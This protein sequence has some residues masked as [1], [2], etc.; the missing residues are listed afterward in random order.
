MPLLAR[1]SRNKGR[2]ITAVLKTLLLH[3][4]HSERAKKAVTSWPFVRPMVRR[5]VAGEQLEEAVAVTRRLN[6]QGFRVALNYLGE[7]VRHPEEAERA[8]DEYLRLVRAIHDHDLQAY[9]SI[10]LT[11]LGLDLS[12]ELCKKHLHTLLETSH[13]LGLFVRIDMESSAYVERTLRLFEELQ[14]RFP[15]LGIVI[16]SYLRRSAQDV[17]RLIEL[18]A[19]VRLVKG[20]Y[21]EP[22]EV[23]YTDKREVDRAYIQLLEKLL[24]EDARKRGVHIAIATHDERIIDRACRYILDH[25][26]RPSEYEFQL[27]MGIRTD[28]HHK[29]LAEGHPVR[30]Y[31]SYGE[32]WF[33]YFM[34]R[35]AERPANVAF[36]LKHLV[37]KPFR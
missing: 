20:A 16:Q 13:A 22:P 34:R 30:I 19:S 6:G 11:Q 31:V 10:K 9:L 4:S 24:S 29:L 1:I 27:L 23:A 21:L 37:R 18:G 35:L 32:D 25:R 14:P 8:L 33:P 26:M 12:E 17:Q 36:L 3:L 5:F 7:H 15:N 2:G 28:L